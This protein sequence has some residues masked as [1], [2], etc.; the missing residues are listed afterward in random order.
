MEYKREI[1][2]VHIAYVNDAGWHASDP[3]V[4]GKTYPRIV[5]SRN[6]DND[7]EKTLKK[8]RGFLGDAESFLSTRDDQVSYGYIIRVSDGFQIEKRVFGKIAN[9]VVP[10]EEPEP[11]PEPEP[12]PEPEPEPDP[13]AD[14]EPEDEPDPE[15]GEG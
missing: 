12:T 4:G 5:D 15:G 9:V 13:D 8:A 6:N 10:D 14:P 11:E 3:A 7:I 1:Y 2:E